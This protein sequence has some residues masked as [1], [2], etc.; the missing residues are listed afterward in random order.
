M[1][2]KTRTA[3]VVLLVAFLVFF[4]VATLLLLR[5]YT[6]LNR[7]SPM[8]STYVEAAGGGGL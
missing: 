5:Y 1:L 4:G 3:I 2:V 6:G 8:N 7:V